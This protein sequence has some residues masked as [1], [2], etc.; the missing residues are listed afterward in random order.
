MA[1]ASRWADPVSTQLRRDPTDVAGEHL[2]AGRVAEAQAIFEDVLRQ[3]PTHARALCGLGSIALRRGELDR[4]FELISHAASAA[5]TDGFTI[6]NLAVAYMARNELPHAEDCS[7]RALDLESGSADLHANLATVLLARGDLENA[8]VAQRHAVGLAPDSAIQ[9]FN[10]ANILIAA[11]D[12]AAAAAEL[13]AAVELDPGHTGAL[14]NLALL[15]KQVGRFEI[16][17]TLLEDARLRDPLNPELLANQADL[18]L[19]M[20]QGEQ[21]LAQIRRAIS[22]APRAPLLQNAHGAILLELGR[23]SEASQILVEALRQAPEDTA[24]T[25]TLA[26]MLRRQ[27]RLDA[28]QTAIDRI[29]S[30]GK[31]R[32]AAETFTA[33]LLLMR[34]RYNDAWDRLAA[35]VG[36]ETAP[37]ADMD[38]GPDAA[39][40]GIAVRLVAFNGA[41]SLF[42][43]RCLPALAGRG[44]E[45]TVICPPVLAPLFKCLPAVREVTA[46]AELDL[47]TLAADGP[48]LLHLD[49]LPRHLRIA[50]D[51]PSPDWPLFRIT[52]DPATA[53]LSGDTAGVWWEG[54]GPGAALLEALA[55]TP[56]MTLVSLQSGPAREAARPLLDAGG[57]VDCGD[58]VRDFGSLAAQIVA[59]D[60]VVAPNGPVAH[61]AAALGVET[62]V[63]VERDGSW[64][65][66]EDGGPAS[67]YPKTRVFRQGADSSWAGTLEAL[68]TSLAPQPADIPASE[69][70]QP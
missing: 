66:P 2:S 6:S 41:S 31:D 69:S 37:L 36:P 68:R 53:S 8:L 29:A 60:R 39:L 16:A 67:W 12:L 28:A 20:G 58:A 5:P 50:P 19:C 35:L 65:W 9:H 55:G 3:Q 14:N 30:P 43:A 64:Y 42:A 10:L 21:A 51:T 47:H 61:L 13:E 40:D 62:W 59:L 52:A 63:L 15:H 24:I 17:K 1:N 11:N 45:I 33:E 57:V 70:I 22:L 25:F 56:A 27:G 44:A 7:R 23:L 49:A 34:G 26:R 32:R 46:L 48:P 54:P 4:G 38:L 18:M